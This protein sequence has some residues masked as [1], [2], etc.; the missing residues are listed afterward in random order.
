MDY[1][2]ENDQFYQ[3]KNS[4][5]R[6]NGFSGKQQEDQSMNDFAQGV[7]RRANC[8]ALSTAWVA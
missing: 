8:L 1:R 6:L 2:V 5:G 4:A 3:T 7:S